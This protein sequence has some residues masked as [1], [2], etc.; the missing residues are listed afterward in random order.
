[1]V[2]MQHPTNYF[3]G[4]VV[5]VLLQPSMRIHL[6]EQWPLVVVL[7]VWMQKVMVEHFEAKELR[8]KEKK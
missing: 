7:V 4:F 2:K 5:V 1:M 6:I 3:L 8:R